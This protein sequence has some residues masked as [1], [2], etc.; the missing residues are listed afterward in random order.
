MIAYTHRETIGRET[1]VTTLRLDLKGAESFPDWVFTL[2]KLQELH[3]F[4]AK[5]GHI[6]FSAWPWADLEKLKLVNCGLE[7]LSI[8]VFLP[9]S[10]Q[11][12]DLSENPGMDWPEQLLEKSPQLETLDFSQ[13]KLPPI[14]LKGL[15]ALPKLRLLFLNQNELTRIPAAVFELI[16]LR[17]L[18]ISSNQIRNLPQSIG[19]L[20]QLDQL[21]AGNNQIRKL[22][23]NI[24]HL[25]ALSRLLLGKN[26]LTALPASIKN[27]LML[28]RLDLHK[29][30]LTAF[31]VV[32]EHLPWLSELDLSGNRIEKL[33]PRLNIFRQLSK[34]DLSRNS[35][36]AFPLSPEKLP[37]LRELKLDHNQ[38]TDLP[39]LPDALFSLSA[40]SNQFTTIPA[41]LL[42]LPDLKELYL[43]R[44]KLQRLPPDF[45]KL[46][47]S[48]IRLGLAGNPVRSEAERLL[49]LRQ[50]KE[51]SGLMSAAER[52][53]LILAQQTARTLDLPDKLSVPF[54]RLLRSDKSV[55]STLSPA[56]LLLALNHPVGKVAAKV[57]RFAQK[58]YGLPAKGRRLG[59]GSTLGIV[60]R[61]FFD[62]AKLEERLAALDIRLLSDYAP[63]QCTHLLLGFPRLTQ[64]IPPAKQVI[65]NE[66]GLV[67]RLDQLEKKPLLK[68]KSES[69]LQRLRQLLTSPDTTNIRLGFRMIAG[70]GLPPQLWNELLAAYYLSERDPGLQ[71][72]IKSYIRLRL[73]DEGKNKFFAALTPQLI[74]WGK[75]KPEKEKL[76]R[77]NRFDLGI[78]QAYLKK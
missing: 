77:R 63:E 4:N 5:F 64:E 18:D 53:D 37:K 54:Y 16:Q 44:N 20:V 27:C 65:M 48:L 55:L 71:L 56:A 40:S 43:E 69:R 13:N 68:E 62:K 2:S 52:R 8:S 19:K 72:Q 15:K 66:K 70:N 41:T 30:K 25:N 6:H 24:G 61:T 58:E 12:L 36:S 10:L 29:N 59:K 73:E 1:A 14:E 17:T 38:L 67:R 50:L 76:L 11:L 42:A 39:R 22:S 31:P 49:K 21:S 23:E 51:L 9:L 47:S 26:R 28:R 75:I 60:G 46:N 78:V 57:R 33:S 34:L 3:L 45:G 32:L 74:K 7:R 35:L